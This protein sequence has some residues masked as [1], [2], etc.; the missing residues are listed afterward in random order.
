[1]P[2]G[3][4]VLILLVLVALGGGVAMAAKKSEPK[5]PAPPP[6]PTPEPPVFQPAPAEP[7]KLPS[8]QALQTTYTP[9]RAPSSKDVKMKK[10]KKMVDDL[11][12]EPN[13]GKVVEAMIL[14]EELDAK[15][16]VIALKDRLQ[17]AIER[18]QQQERLHPGK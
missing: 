16:T 8:T 15:Q 5:K 3:L 13:V 10:L 6:P 2:A 12:P 7:V 18:G 17:V 14:A 11:G 4:G 1:M 9:T